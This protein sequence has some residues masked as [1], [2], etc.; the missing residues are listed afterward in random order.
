MHTYYTYNKQVRK[1]D[2]QNLLTLGKLWEKN[3]MKRIYF[4]NLLD[5]YGLEITRYNTGNISSARLDGQ[6]ISNSEARRLIDRMSLG[7]LWYDCTAKEFKSQYIP[8]DMVSAMVAEI[9]RRIA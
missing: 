2:E 4:N 3:G 6:E 1:M 8:S 5:L 7:K 9:K